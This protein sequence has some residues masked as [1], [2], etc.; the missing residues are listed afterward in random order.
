MIR[1]E[2]CLLALALCNAVMQCGSRGTL[3][4]NDWH[5]AHPPSSGMSFLC[6]T[7]PAYALGVHIL[8]TLS[9]GGIAL[10]AMRHFVFVVG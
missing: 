7:V 5:I 10:I 1:H 2:I 3:A 8:L 9:A 4:R 6:F